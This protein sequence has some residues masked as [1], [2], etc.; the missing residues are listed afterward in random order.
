MESPPREVQEVVDDTEPETGGL[1]RPASGQLPAG[2]PGSAIPLHGMTP[3]PASQ[4]AGE[5]PDRGSVGSPAVLAR[6]PLAQ[7]QPVVS[8][9]MALHTTP[10]AEHG[11]SSLF[12]PSSD[13]EPGHE[14]H[15]LMSDRHEPLP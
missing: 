3:V 9:E 15:L 4:E 6:N 8:V 14:E 10:V 12:S 11:S 5:A 7:S 13:G 2:I 1:E